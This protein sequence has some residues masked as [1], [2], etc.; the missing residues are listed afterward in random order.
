M[1]NFRKNNIERF[2]AALKGKPR[3]AKKQGLAGL[4]SALLLIPTW[5]YLGFLSTKEPE[6]PK[7]TWVITDMG[8][9]C[10]ELTVEMSE[11]MVVYCVDGVLH[12]NT[13][14]GE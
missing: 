7:D 1:N 2:A 4:I 12:T 9:P 5:L 13:W 8:Y 11:G 6:E 3:G 14:S 10:P